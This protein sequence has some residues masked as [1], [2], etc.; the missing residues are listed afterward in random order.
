[1]SQQRPQIYD[2]GRHHVVLILVISN[3]VTFTTS[4]LQSNYRHKKKI[5]YSLYNIQGI[6]K[7]NDTK[8]ILLTSQ[9]SAKAS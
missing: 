5:N 6:N 2:Y 4:F 9:F 1:M 3:N 7:H 8:I